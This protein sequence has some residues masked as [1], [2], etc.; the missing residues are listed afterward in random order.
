MPF[1]YEPD[2]AIWTHSANGKYYMSDATAYEASSSKGAPPPP[3]NQSSLSAT[4]ERPAKRRHRTQSSQLKRSAPT[5]RGAPPPTHS[6]LSA[7][8]ERQSEQRH[9]IRSFRLKRSAPTHPLRTEYCGNT[10]H[11]KL[12]AQ[13]ERLKAHQACSTVHVYS[14]TNSGLPISLNCIGKLGVQL[15]ANSSRE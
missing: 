3:T 8:A 14:T 13:E 9:N 5:S 1:Y 12:P 6:A 11:T 4:A 7:A 15:L 10:K 2:V